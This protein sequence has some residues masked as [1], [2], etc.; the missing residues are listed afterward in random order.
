MTFTSSVLRVADLVRKL[1]GDSMINLTLGT[2][3]NRYSI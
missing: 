3:T 2:T 1:L